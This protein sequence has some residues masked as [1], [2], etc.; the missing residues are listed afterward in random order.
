[1]HHRSEIYA[2][3]PL[4]EV[5]DHG[6]DRIRAKLEKVLGDLAIQYGLGR[7][8]VKMAKGSGGG[9]SGGD[10]TSGTKK[11]PV[12]SNV[13]GDGVSKKRKSMKVEV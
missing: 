3:P 5:N 9:S 6:S 8:V 4:L 2:D 7:E 11:R 13:E 1:M 10:K 12:K